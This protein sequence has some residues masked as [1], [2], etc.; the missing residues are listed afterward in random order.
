[1]RIFAPSLGFLV[2]VLFVELGFLEGLGL[3]IGVR[4][5]M[6]GFLLMESGICGDHGWWLCDAGDFTQGGVAGTDTP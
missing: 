2:M 5:F 1:M 6:D 4:R 3:L